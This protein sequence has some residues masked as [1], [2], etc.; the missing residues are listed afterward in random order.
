MTGTMKE[1][2]IALAGNPNSGKSTLF[3]AIT[4]A[5]QHVGNY[6]GITVEKKEGTCI[7]GGVQLRFVD[8]PG[9]YSLTAYSLEELV[10]R[11][12]LVQSWPPVVVNVV[13]ASNLERNL[14]LTVQLRELGVPLV[15]ALN[16]MDVAA[17]RGM[18]IDAARLAVRLG[19]PVVPIV[20]RTGEGKEA[21]LE[22]VLAAVDMLG[23]QQPLR[24]SYGADVDQVL[25]DMV[26]E[27]G[28]RPF[29]VG[30]YPPRWVAL[31]Y[32]EMDEQICGRGRE[33]QLDTSTRLEAIAARLTEHTQKT[34]DSY[35]E[36]IIADHRYGLIAALLR[37]GV[38]TRKEMADRL[39]FSDRLDQLLTNRFWGPVI[40]L[41][42]L[43]GVYSLTFNYSEYPVEWL[44]TLFAWL[45]QQMEG[46]LPPGPVRSLVVSGIIG[47]LGGVMGFVPLIVVM[48]LAIA[49]LEDTG[50]LAR[51]AYMLDRIFRTFGLHGSS[52]MAYIISGG[53]AGGCAVP[54]VMATR[55]L[56]SP[57]ERIATLLTAPYMN[58]G[59]KLPVF[60]MLIAAFFPAS[61]AAMMFL[62]TIVSWIAALFLAKLFRW[63]I[64]PGPSTPFLLEL[65]PYRLPTFK[66]LAIHTWER[67]W[68]YVQKAGTMI[69][70]ISILVWGL[71]TFPGLSDQERGLYEAK[72]SELL[73]RLPSDMAPEALEKADAATLSD[74]LKGFRQELEQINQAEALSTLKQSFGG[75]FGTAI[76][77]L[78]R[79]CGFDWRVNIALLGGFAAKEVII[80]SL[81]TAYS[82]GRLP[83]EKSASLSQVL[84]ADPRW[85]RLTAFSLIVFIMLYAPCLATIV[86]IVRESGSWKWGVF[87]MVFNTVIAY[88]VAVVVYQAGL[89]LR[90]GV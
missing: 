15:V 38:L 36:A 27:I 80:S 46:L 49:F 44:G 18:E 21:L 43:Y 64:L 85:N 30:P 28:Q 88:V 9:T 55:T 72:R 69:L 68:Q 32:L 54:G 5:R 79:W 20:A 89:W 74:E 90:I 66:G 67:T 13:D 25:D 4:G 41:L 70:A 3:N 8:L 53:I 56:R 11:D 84:A 75:R 14:Y 1:Y 62:L 73:S 19:V 77:S 39:F 86:C 83:A 33:E 82:L 22:T 7:F 35:P 34:M 29:L 48:F 17:G 58:C 40:M 59:A 76:E 26:R 42:V 52:V 45:G 81:G 60:A 57:R 65:P 71:M 24:I 16:M 12:F 87:S 61:Q 6:P 37:G 31:K 2:L 51:V 47:G 78:T 50:Y 23:N 10:A 63:T